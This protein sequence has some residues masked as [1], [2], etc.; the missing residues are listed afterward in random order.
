[1]HVAHQKVSHFNTSLHFSPAT[2]EPMLYMSG[3][4]PCPLNRE[5]TASTVIRV[6]DFLLLWLSNPL[7]TSKFICSPSDFEAGTPKLVAALP[8]LDTGYSCHFFFEWSTHVACPTNPRAELKKHHYIG[9][10]LL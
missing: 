4:S 5:E 9:L 3:G 8:P 1:M 2:N 6:S 7:T 10:G